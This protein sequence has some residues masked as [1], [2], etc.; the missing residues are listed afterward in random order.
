MCNDVFVSSRPGSLVLG[1]YEEQEN[2]HIRTF[3]YISFFM[4]IL[5][6]KMHDRRWDVVHVRV[7]DR[8]HQRRGDNIAPCAGTKSLIRCQHVYVSCWQGQGT[9]KRAIHYFLWYVCHP[10]TS[11]WISVVSLEGG[12][13]HMSRPRMK[14]ALL[15]AL[16][17]HLLW[18]GIDHQSR[19]RWCVGQGAEFLLH[20]SL[21]SIC[22][23]RDLS[24]A[25]WVGSAH[26]GNNTVCEETPCHPSDKGV[27]LWHTPPVNLL[28]LLHNAERDKIDHQAWKSQHSMLSKTF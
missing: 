2:K 6:Y 8:G 4:Y 12:R 21:Y 10:L 16:D 15:L 5:C 7:G 19:T 24:T 20:L 13:R 27:R 18:Q 11:T 1:C 14:E 17:S 23:W 22:S 9:P 25:A 3:V 26:H 28:H